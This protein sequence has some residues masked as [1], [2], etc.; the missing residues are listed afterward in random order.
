M[1]LTAG[2]ISRRGKEL[3]TIHMKRG[4]RIGLAVG[5]CLLFATLMPAADVEGFLI[6]KLCSRK[7]I[8]G[9]QKVAAMHTRDCALMP[10]CVKSGYGVF[11]ADGKFLA[12]DTKGSQEAEKALKASNRKDNLKVRVSGD[13]DGD[14]I[15]VATLKL[16]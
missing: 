11:T 16:L 7:A 4:H 3:E 2:S 9:G 6:D 10:P 8:E 1:L 12:L 15:K 14:S 13:V 5:V